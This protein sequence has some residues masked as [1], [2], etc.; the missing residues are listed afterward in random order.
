MSIG[1]SL[2][3]LGAVI[4]LSGILFSLG[5]RF[6]PRLGRLPWDI[7]YRGKDSVLLLPFGTS[8]LLSIVLSLVLWLVQ[9]R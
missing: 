3:L 5:E 2:I 1:R 6:R 8:I 4:L 9:R 7:V